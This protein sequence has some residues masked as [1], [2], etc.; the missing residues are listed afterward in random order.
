MILYWA[1][2]GLSLVSLVII[3]FYGF[4]SMKSGD[5][6]LSQRIMRYRIGVQFLVII[7]IL[8]AIYG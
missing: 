4:Y 6:V 1:L 3:L 8:L 5:V 2:A 7:F